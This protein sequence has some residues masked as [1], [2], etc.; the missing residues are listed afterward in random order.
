MLALGLFSI[1]ET[2]VVRKDRKSQ[3]KRVTFFSSSEKEKHH[4]LF[5]HWPCLQAHTMLQQLP[6]CL[7]SFPGS[8]PPP[9]KSLGTRLAHTMLQQLP[10][11]DS[12]MIQYMIIKLVCQQ[13]FFSK[14]RCLN[15]RNISFTKS[16]NP[17]RR[18]LELNF[19]YVDYQTIAP[20]ILQY[21]R[22]LDLCT[23]NKNATF[24]KCL[25]INWRGYP[26][27]TN[28]L[29]NKYDDRR[30]VY[31]SYK[32]FVLMHSFVVHLIHEIF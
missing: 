3:P 6:N 28:W 15:R 9:H 18:L 5:F 22:L 21:L 25:S 26:L 8:P 7:A 30:L 16:L 24:L 20:P 13:T 12:N 32:M 31:F 10:N 11:L 14:E 19:K 1:P 27:P 23:R 2:I 29:L 17:A 4:F